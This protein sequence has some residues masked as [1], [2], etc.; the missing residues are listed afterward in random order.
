MAFTRIVWEIKKCVFRYVFFYTFVS[1]V[2]TL[3]KTLFVR[4]RFVWVPV[5]FRVLHT[6]SHQSLSTRRA[7]TLPRASAHDHDLGM[8]IGAGSWV[9]SFSVPWV[10]GTRSRPPT[11][12]FIERYFASGPFPP[13]LP[14][15]L[16]GI[17]A[18]K[19][20]MTPVYA[21]TFIEKEC[22]IA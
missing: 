6:T 16:V 17:Y 18:L 20:K 15:H 3:R 12:P 7:P 22:A 21:T 14:M 8:V 10:L 5:H 19:Q 11:P 4:L 2:Q 13:S 9:P 1:F